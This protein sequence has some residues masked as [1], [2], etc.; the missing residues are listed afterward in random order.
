MRTGDGDR[1]GR[2]GQGDKDG[3]MGLEVMR[4]ESVEMERTR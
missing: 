1:D 2:W 3:V 4:M